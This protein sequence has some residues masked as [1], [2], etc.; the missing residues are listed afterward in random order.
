M[1]VAFISG[2]FFPKAGGAQVQ[3]HNIANKLS[4]L[5]IKVKLFIYNK[6]NIKN[7]NYNIVVL[8]KFVFNLVYFFKYFFDLNLS[9]L[10]TPYVTKLI[11]KHKID[12]WHFNF[13]NFKSLILINVLKNLD[14]KVVVT[15]HGID[16]Q[17]DRKINYGYRLNKKYDIFLKNTLKR[18]DLFTYLSKTIQK[19]LMELGIQEDKM[20]YFPNSVNIKKFNEYILP[21][22]K[23]KKVLNFITVAR[24]A[25]KKK[26]FDLV[27]DICTSLIKNNINFKW[28]IIGE[29]TNLLLQNNFFKNNKHLFDIISNIEN[30]DEEFFPHS[31]LIKHYKSADLYINLS[32]IESFGVTYIESLAS[33]VP[34]ISFRSKGSNEIVKDKINGILVEKDDIPNFVSQICQMNKNKNIIENIKSNCIDSIKKFD[35]DINTKRLLDIYKNLN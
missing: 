5:G 32:R 26:G 18:I 20:V 2:V 31:D 28:K 35:L 22:S 17:I 1:N 3:V 34:I 30:L 21:D 7:N 10:L 8:N 6:T 25:E 16:L 19:D 12:I 33:K 11:N 13:I 29:N 14:K 24:F 4:K 23:D 15:F 9:F 27:Q